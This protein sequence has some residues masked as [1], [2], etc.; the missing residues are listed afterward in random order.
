MRTRRDRV[1]SASLARR[2]AGEGGGGARARAARDVRFPRCAAAPTTTFTR[3]VGARDN[4]GIFVLTTTRQ[5]AR[6]QGDLRASAS[7][8]RG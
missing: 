6:Q 4:G 7:S 2:T 5:R 1:G 3:R 8:A